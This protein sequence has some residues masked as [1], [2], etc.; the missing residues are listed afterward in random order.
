MAT[1]GY[2][3][4][5]DDVRTLLEPRCAFRTVARSVA[6]AGSRTSFAKAPQLWET[7]PMA[8]AVQDPANGFKCSMAVIPC[9][10]LEQAVSY[11]DRFG[12][13]HR[14]LRVSAQLSLWFTVRQVRWSHWD[15]HRS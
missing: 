14:S 13:F 1:S 11:W 5:E 9:R 4:A 6:F 8:Q 2:T 12:N 15:R 10:S 7:R 3:E